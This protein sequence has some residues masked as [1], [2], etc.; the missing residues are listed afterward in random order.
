LKEVF[1][2]LT[3]GRRPLKIWVFVANITNEFILGLN[4]LRAYDASVDIGRQTLR[5]AEEEIP[6]WSPGAGPRPSSLV[7]ERVKGRKK[8]HRGRKRLGEPKELTRE[9]YG[10]RKELTDSSR[11]MTRRPRVARREGNFVREYS[12]RVNVAPKTRKGRAIG[13]RNRD[14]KKQLHLESERTTS[15]INRNIIGLE[16][17]KLHESSGLRHIRNWRLWMGRPPSQVEKEAVLA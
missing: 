16:I 3:L 10:S 5:L 11:K 2:T 1:L 12:T 9:I 14:F 6:L 13:I 7:V 15:A 17:T 4:I 8:R